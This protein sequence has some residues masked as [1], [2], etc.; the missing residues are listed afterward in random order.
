[1]SSV[2]ILMGKRFRCLEE[3]DGK[4]AYTFC[5]VGT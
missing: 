3:G 2:G 5:D 1:M 4:F